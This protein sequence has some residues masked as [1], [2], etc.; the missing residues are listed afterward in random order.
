[1]PQPKREKESVQQECEP[2]KHAIESLPVRVAVTKEGRLIVEPASL[3]IKLGARQEAEWKC[4]DGSL[5]VRF[6]PNQTPF[7]G[8]SLR[9]PQNA[10]CRSGI[11]DPRKT[12][13]GSYRYVVLVTTRDGIFVSQDQ[14]VVIA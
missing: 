4:A 6:A 9:S 2:P 10:A 1:M 14:A 11:P 5:E 12:K 3:P 7:L 13:K 8:A